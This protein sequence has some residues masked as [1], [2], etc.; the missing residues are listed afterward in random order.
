MP[1]YVWFVQ[2]IWHLTAGEK[3]QNWEEWTIV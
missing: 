2:L 3:N 1:E